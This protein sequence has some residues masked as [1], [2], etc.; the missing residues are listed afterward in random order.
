MGFFHY[1]FEQDALAWTPG[2]AKLFGLSAAARRATL[3]DWIAASTRDDRDRV[4][5]IAAR[6]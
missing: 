1:Q 2:Q 6:R 3:S 5:Q 4:E